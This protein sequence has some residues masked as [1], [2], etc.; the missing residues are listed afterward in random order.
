MTG[1]WPDLFDTLAH[2]IREQ[3]R[4]GEMS[5]GALL[6]SE[7][8]LARRASTKRYSIRKAL[9]MLQREGLVSPI[10]GL[11]WVV[12]HSHSTEPDADPPLPRYRKIA[13]E[14]RAAIE[15]GRPAAG[16]ALPSE[17]DLV[18]RHLVSRAT[19][20]QALALLEFEGLITAHPGKGRYIRAQ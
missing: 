9:A 16:F 14:L 3:I 2:S 11:G 17:A 1:R 6:P 4:A 8:E 18:A 13:A 5:A 10:P 15:A 12:Q 7:A 19:I 20:R